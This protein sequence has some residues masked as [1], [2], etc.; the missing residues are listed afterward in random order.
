MLVAASA[1]VVV[2]ENA[3]VPGVAPTVRSL[4]VML[5]AVTAVASTVD[6]KQATK[7]VIKNNLLM[8][9]FFCYIIRRV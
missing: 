8:I 3:I 6:A 2:T 1:V 4:G 9:M 7:A 5:A